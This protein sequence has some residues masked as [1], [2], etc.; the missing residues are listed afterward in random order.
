MMWEYLEDSASESHITEGPWVAVL[1]LPK[2]QL[3]AGYNDTERWV[4]VLT[5]RWGS[6]FKT[7]SQE[8]N[9]QETI[10]SLLER[11]YG[12]APDR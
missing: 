5:Y 1:E 3:P 8:P 4:P 11:G 10:E 9:A 2:D 7:L 6:R 12:G